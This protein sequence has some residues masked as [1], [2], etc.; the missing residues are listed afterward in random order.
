MQAKD[1]GA[2]LE[3]DMHFGCFLFNVTAHE[4]SVGAPDHQEP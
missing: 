1:P 3:H 2:W 4:S